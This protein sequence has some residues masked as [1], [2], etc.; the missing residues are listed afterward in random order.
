MNSVELITVVYAGDLANLY[1]H[2]LSLKR[3]WMDHHLDH[4]KWT[5]VVEDCVTQGR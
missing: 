1:Y 3:Y 5:I 2:A 4:C